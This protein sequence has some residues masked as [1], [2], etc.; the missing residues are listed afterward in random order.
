MIKMGTQLSFMTTSC[1]I[2]WVKLFKYEHHLQTSANGSRKIIIK[3]ILEILIE[4]Q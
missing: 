2:I 4:S 1:D 3:K